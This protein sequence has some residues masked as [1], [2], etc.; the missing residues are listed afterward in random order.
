M[1]VVNV[2][3]MSGA[4][5]NSW[6]TIKK[7]VVNRLERDF[8]NIKLAKKLHRLLDFKYVY[9]GWVFL[10]VQ[11]T[12]RCHDITILLDNEQLAF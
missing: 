4:R 11:K 3:E 12:I 1:V 2:F 10:C 6:P 8:F 9:I 5:N 7:T